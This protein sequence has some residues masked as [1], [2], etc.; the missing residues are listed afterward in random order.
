[1]VAMLLNN[2]SIKRSSFK[3]VGVIKGEL[4]FDKNGLSAA[5]LNI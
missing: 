3:A 5:V 2:T 4:K 1:M